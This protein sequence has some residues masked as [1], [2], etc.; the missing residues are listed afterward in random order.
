MT[1]F[2]YFKFQFVSITK[3]VGNELFF[4]N[5]IDILFCAQ[6]TAM[7]NILSRLEI[8]DLWFID[9]RVHKFLFIAFY[10]YYKKKKM[11]I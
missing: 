1:I 10:L 7:I 6:L 2:Y 11:Y 4:E 5:I 8:I 9:L 3:F